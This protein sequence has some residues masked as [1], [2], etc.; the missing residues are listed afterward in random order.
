MLAHKHGRGISNSPT[1][2][3]RCPI[4]EQP[5]NYTAGATVIAAFSTSDPSPGSYE[6]LVAV[7]RPGEPITGSNTS[8]SLTSVSSRSQNPRSSGG[9]VVQRYTTSDFLAW[10]APTTVLYLP[11]GEGPTTPGKLG[12]GDIWTVKSV[13]RNDTGYLLMAF[14]GDSCTSFHAP[15]KLKEHAFKATKQDGSFR[16]HDDTNLIWSR[17]TNQ[18]VSFASYLIASILSF[19]H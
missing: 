18:W 8:F 17:T 16:D 19:L 10:S 3:F 9:V 12:D 5:E 2:K 4:D 15:L 14:Y 6:V 1:L 11:N 13:D 7:G